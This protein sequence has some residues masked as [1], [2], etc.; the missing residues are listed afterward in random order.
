MFFFSWLDAFLFPPSLRAK[1]D[2][3]VPDDDFS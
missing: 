2:F 1:S 3:A